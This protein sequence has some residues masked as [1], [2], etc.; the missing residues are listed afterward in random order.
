MK[1]TTPYIRKAQY[2]E[3]DQMAIIHH[4][5]Y[6]RWMEEARVDFMEQIGYGYDKA[7]ESGMDFVLTGISCEYKSM[8]R[9]GESVSIKATI[10]A[11][12]PVLL[13]VSYEMNDVKTGQLRF[14]GE[15]RHCCFNSRKQRP[16]ILTKLLPELYDLLLEYYAPPAGEDA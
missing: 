1:T 2:Y 10:T 14:L 11:L 7:T 4:S 8:V 16:A 5:N 13:T 6:V 15:S 3:T 12:N 9:F